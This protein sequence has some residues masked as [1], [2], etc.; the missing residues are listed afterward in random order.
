MIGTAT[1]SPPLLAAAP[2]PTPA[3]KE[4]QA[5]TA[6]HPFAEM[7]RQNRLADAPA[8]SAPL[9]ASTAADGKTRPQTASAED[10]A[11][12]TTPSPSLARR[13]AAQ[14][15]ARLVAAARAPSRTTALGARPTAATEK[16]S[17]AKEDDYART[18]APADPTAAANPVAA[19]RAD[20]A[21]HAGVATGEQPSAATLNASA[22]A[23]NR[24]ARGLESADGTQAAG[25]IATGD[26]PSG[27]AAGGP[28]SARDALAEAAGTSRRAITKSG[29]DAT[30][31]AAGASF[32]EALAEPKMTLHAT[33]SP[34]EDRSHAAAAVSAGLAEP[35]RN[36][37]SAA[38]AAGTT[39]TVPV[40][41]DAPDFAAAFGLQ[42]GN[43]ARDG[44]QR[45]ELHLNP[46]D[47]GPV[48][49]QITLDGTQARV[50]FGAD[51]AATR[52]AI[53]AG[54]PELAS[55][56]R[57]AGFTLA[58]GGVTQHS[59]SHGGQTD[60]AGSGQRGSR[61]GAAEVVARLDGAA[62]RA[63]R[64]SADGG[65]DLYA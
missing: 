36:L 3:D 10:G 29:E 33:A 64:R 11:E 7:L 60:D 21:S 1:R 20:L 52:H 16:R 34:I 57:D 53:E 18:V 46:T 4:P 51:V 25:S 43:L 47:M 8:A 23:A 63:I 58:G 14:D 59:G 41:F 62:Q 30:R 35:L 5:G 12:A 2:T 42:V 37:A 9:K 31:D 45:A 22:N 17:V 32:A 24:I 28:E 15:K 44:I 39:E 13:D 61:R 65:I 55:A 26:A 54:L 50:D 49:V 27:N 56:L 38:P 6:A 48:S 40:P 19:G